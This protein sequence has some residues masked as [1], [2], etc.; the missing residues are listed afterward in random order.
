MFK[1]ALLITIFSVISLSAQ[2][3]T[4]VPEQVE[5][6]RDKAYL[7]K[8]LFSDPILS[9]DGTISCESCHS[10]SS[11]GDDGKPVS[12]GVGGKKGDINSP[13]IFNSRFNFKQFWN[14][15][16]RDLKEQ[17]LG[18]IHNPI[19]MDMTMREVVERL[20]L[21]SEYN[22]E[23]IRL[24]GRVTERAVADALAEFE[25]A[26]V[27]PNSRFDLYLKGK[28]KLTQKE[29]KGYKIFK[30]KGCISCH[31]GVN[32]GGNMFQKFGVMIEREFDDKG[33]YDVTGKVRDKYYYKVPT[34]RNIE[35]TAPYF[36]TGETYSLVVAV[37]EM[38]FRQLG[39]SL[40]EEE[41][42]LIVEFL[43]TLNGEL[44]QIIKD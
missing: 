15:R 39:I 29:L 38:A 7:G 42:N 30:S 31:H 19:E 35:Q 5:F 21:H 25:K 3:I 2:L 13:T 8:K 11:G 37:E 36:H 24:Y 28:T 43:K 33:R 17:A 1:T 22:R 6:N 16:A 12:T 18:P 9:R 32:I 4:P 14:G 44:P 40:S 20:R 10:L 34:L 41:V 26:L 23:F 27:T